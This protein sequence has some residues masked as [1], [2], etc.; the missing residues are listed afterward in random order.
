MW[1]TAKQG[2]PPKSSCQRFAQVGASFYRSHDGSLTRIERAT[3]AATNTPL[4]ALAAKGSKAKPFVVDIIGD[5]LVLEVFDGPYAGVDARTGALRWRRDRD[6]NRKPVYQVSTTTGSE[7]LLAVV[8]LGTTSTAITLERLD[9]ATGTSKWKVPVADK[10]EGLEA[11]LATANRIYMVQ[12]G[13]LPSDDY[14]IVALDAAGKPAWSQDF[15]SN[16]IPHFSTA[17]DDLV[18]QVDEGFTVYGAA[19]GKATSWKVP[20]A[21][22]PVVAGTTVYALRVDG[23]LASYDI[24][25]GKPHWETRLYAKDPSFYTDPTVIGAADG[26]VYV[27]DVDQLRSFDDVSGK[28]IASLGIGLAATSD[29]QIHGGTPA[30]TMC[31]GRDLVALDPSTPA[32]E[33][34]IKVT[35]RIACTNCDKSTP[36]EV[37]FSDDVVTLEANRK[38]AVTATARGELVLRVRDAN[39]PGAKSLKSIAFTSDRTVKLGTIEV[40]VPEMGPG[41]D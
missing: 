32:P 30:V 15:K 9:A 28:P 18:Q 36:I 39:F 37:R 41:E 8:E 16:L 13:H 33:H 35:G 12:R 31:K 2:R 14:T 29:L 34:K 40:A 21:T 10:R 23:M 24:A 26:V 3:G 6:P 38:F 4:P 19:A 5:T 25:T 7:L 17:N 11:F 1:T 22:H 27:V 20:F